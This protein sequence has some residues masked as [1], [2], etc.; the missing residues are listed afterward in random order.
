MTPSA[1]DYSLIGRDAALA[2]ANGLAAAEWYAC[3]IPRKALKELMKR[4]DGPALRDT[5]VWFAALMTTAAGGIYF[6]G[7]WWAVPFF[8][9]YGVLYGS[10]SDSRPLTWLIFY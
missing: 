8:L 7:S 1:R 2:E 3:P 5:A 4:S 6:W 9:A 10:A